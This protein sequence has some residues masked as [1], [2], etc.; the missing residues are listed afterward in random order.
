MGG[1]GALALGLTHPDIFGTIGAHSPALP[2]FAEMRDFF[3]NAASFADV[4][5]L[6]LAETV[7]PAKVDTRP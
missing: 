5:P 4:D 2:P 1:F 7:S 6:A 3:D